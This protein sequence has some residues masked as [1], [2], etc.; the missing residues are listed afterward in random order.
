VVHN[1][2][3]DPALPDVEERVAKIPH[4]ALN[5]DPRTHAHLRGI[6]RLLD[7]YPGER[8][9]VGEVFLL[10]TEKVAAYFGDGD[11]L[12]LCFNFPPLFAPWEAPRW[13]ECIESAARCFD[14][15]DA[16]PAWVLSNHDFP[17]HRTRYGSETRAR[18]AA[19]LLLGLRGTPFLYMG[20]ELGLED[21]VI[22]PERVVDPGGRDGCR[23]PLP[24]TRSPG[25]GWPADPWL[26]FPPDAAARNVE[27]QR[28]DPGSM[29][30]L[31]RRLIAARR[32]SPAL[33]AGSLEL[34]PA[35]DGVLAWRR[36]VERD[37]RCV[38]VNFTPQPAE[39]ELEGPWRIEVAS[40][41]SGEGTGF[42]GTLAPDRALVL[43]LIPPATE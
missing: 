42:D 13:R 29:L 31:Y 37:V 28:E 12:P 3:K 32:A 25:H 30:H 7:G 5:D 16:W 26:P 24:W 22:P 1:I 21:A 36:E 6:R 43:A 15:K 18:A 11:E 4:S 38:V 8:M 2:G 20:E 27:A 23:A 33:N 17:R 40:D 9:A 35:P 39:L 10:D 14:P 34:L 41:G 19:V